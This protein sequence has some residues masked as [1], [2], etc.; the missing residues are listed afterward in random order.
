MSY[1]FEDVDRAARD[2]SAY[3]DPTRIPHGVSARLASDVQRDLLRAG[4]RRAPDLLVSTTTVSVASLGTAITLP[5]HLHVTR[6]EVNFADGTDP[7]PLTLVPARRKDDFTRDR[8]AYLVGPSLY[9][10]GEAADW[11]DVTNVTV[12]YVPWAADFTALAD[13]IALPDDAKD[14]FV[15]ALAK[16]FAF[17]VNG[18]PFDGQDPRNGTIAL[19]VTAFAAEAERAERAWTAALVDQ[20][21][22][23][24]RLTIRNSNP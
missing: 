17:R 19:D 23:F 5:A 3:F 6:C 1:T 11:T 9:L 8:A 21:R 2:R 14:A 15:A 7:E 24:S 13:T 18:L 10:T 22:A 20:V 4:N 12:T 16:A